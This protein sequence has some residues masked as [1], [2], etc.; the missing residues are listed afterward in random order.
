MDIKVIATDLDGTLLY[1]KTLISKKN[2]IALNK[3]I[4]LGGIVCFLTGRCFISAKK[5]ADKFESKTGN[6]IHYIS[7]LK[8]SI[9]YDNVNNLFLYKNEINK[10]LSVQIFEIIK[11]YDCV[12]G[13]YLDS[14]LE[15][16]NRMVIYGSDKIIKFLHW[17]K[18]FQNCEI[19]HE[20]DKNNLAYKINISG[21]KVKLSGLLHKKNLNLANN[22]I[23]SKL[24][25]QID[26]SLTSKY[27]YEITAKN[28]NKGQAI[29]YI[30]ELLNI[31]TNNFAAFGDSENDIDMF[32]NAGLAIAIGNKSKALIHNSTH[33][34]FG[35]QKNAVARGINHYIFNKKIKK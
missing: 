15:K 24:L 14:D 19:I 8:G 3:F 5:I 23:R 25:D 10:S 28:S 26:L 32:K 16:S 35:L 33:V 13:A 6:K 4:K 21:V 30:S 22:E 17:F 11:K 9:L 31:S 7:C 1:K 34:I 20:W 29:K 12:L 18:F 27:M 2:I